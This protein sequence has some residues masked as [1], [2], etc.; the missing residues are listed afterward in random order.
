VQKQFTKH[1]NE[2]GEVKGHY[3]N[4]TAGTCEEMFKRA[5]FAAQLGVPIIMHFFRTSQSKWVAKAPSQLMLGSHILPGV[6]MVL[7]C[8]LLLLTTSPTITMP[9]VDLRMD[10]REAMHLVPHMH[11]LHQ[12]GLMDQLAMAIP[13]N[14][15][16]DLNKAVSLPHTQP[17]PKVLPDS[18]LMDAP[19]SWYPARSQ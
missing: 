1:K 13:L 4:A 15:P 11:Q 12:W 14:L 5:T 8:L 9:L 2:T 6:P 17:R 18:L 7:Q 16:M 3:L 10:A 19:S